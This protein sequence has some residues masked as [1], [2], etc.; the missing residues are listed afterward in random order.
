MR[1]LH[2]HVR[3]PRDRDRIQAGPV[4]QGVQLLRQYAVD[5]PAGP[6]RHDAGFRLVRLQELLI[7]DS[8]PLSPTG[9]PVSA[10]DTGDP[11]RDRPPPAA[12]AFD[13]YVQSRG[14]ALLRFAYVLSG[15]AHLAED[16]VQE[17]LARMHRRW[18]RV[19]AMDHAEAYVRQAIVR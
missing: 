14:W 9:S 5:R 15:D 7:S 16:L 13:D 17:V 8:M 10:T 1:Q 6:R 12:A 4:H 3:Q 19:V 18:E 11:A 2:G